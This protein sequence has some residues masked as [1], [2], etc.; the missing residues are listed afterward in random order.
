M[1]LGLL[2]NEAL[3]P[4]VNWTT[5]SQPLFRA[6]SERPNVQTI[7]PP[8]LHRNR[9]GDWNRAW[10]AARKCDTFFWF[11]SAWRPEPPLHLLSVLN[12][13]ARRAAYAFDAWKPTLGKV[14]RAAIVQRLDP[15]FISYQE[16][17]DDLKL[18]FPKAKF[19]WLPFGID[20]DVFYPRPQGK[21]VFAFWMG[22][23]HEPLH[24]ALLAYCETRGLKYLYSNDGRYTPDDLGRVSSSAEYF[25][26]TPPDPRR[27]GGYSPL[28]MRYLE[29]LA[30]GARLLGTLPKSGEYERLLPL[31]A[32]C[33]VAEDGS[34]L[35]EKLDADR[36]NPGRLRAVEAAGALVREHHSW[37]RRGEQIYDRLATG[38][39]LV[40]PSPQSAKPGAPG[41]PRDHIAA[42]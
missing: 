36:S 8:P 13:F 23:R 20:T 37:R 33:Q 17:I 40:F 3:N 22:R 29:G 4:H 2:S 38:A 42:A 12:P 27:S 11:Q 15:C 19:E 41:S 16:A 31:D 25:I 9:L 5:L 6:M 1:E 35:A 28:V 24:Q 30:A 26:V 10:S 14:G 34:D 21:T 7:A 39:P 18:K 32:I